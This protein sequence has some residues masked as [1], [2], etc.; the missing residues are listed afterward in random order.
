[1]GRLGMAQLDTTPTGTIEFR[2]EM[3]PCRIYPSFRF[4]RIGNWFRDICAVHKRVSVRGPN[5][6]SHL[7]VGVLV[8]ILGPDCRTIRCRQKDSTSMEGARALDGS[9][10]NVDCSSDGRVTK[11]RRRIRLNPTTDANAL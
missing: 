9:L 11:S 2:D 3:F 5:A 1:M 10:A 7:S 6:S 8:G 4:G